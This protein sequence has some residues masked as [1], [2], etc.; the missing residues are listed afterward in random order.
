[1]KNQI[2]TIVAALAFFA[3]FST[4]ATAA[5]KGKNDTADFIVNGV[6]L[7]TNKSHDSKCKLEVFNEN[8]LVD[9]SEIKMNK[10]FECKLKKNV[11][12]T[13]RFTKEGYAPLMISFNTALE[14]D[15]QVLDN[16]FE[17]ETALIENDAARF[18]DQDQIEFPVGHV[19]FNKDTKR[20][21]ARDVYTNNYL[22]ALYKTTPTNAADVAMVYTSEKQP[23]IVK[24]YV[25][26][27]KM[28]PGMC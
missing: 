17:F 18:M 27:Q 20:F 22:A 2:K 10:P 14:S 23:D 6:I 16:L 5:N 15:A 25:T 3:A 26:V 21:E 28:A 24:E 19:A 9:F 12:Y 4:A 7:K 13:F 8:T 11:W 1:M